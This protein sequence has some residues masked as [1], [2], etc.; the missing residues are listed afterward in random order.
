[1]TYVT[2]K[3]DY[4][5]IEETEFSDRRPLA[6]EMLRCKQE[7]IQNFAPPMPTGNSKLTVVV[8]QGES[9]EWIN[10]LARW[11]EKEEFSIGISLR[12]LEINEGC[13]LLSKNEYA[14]NNPLGY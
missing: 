10:I 13:C 4:V 9:G 6:V 3:I 12:E 2:Q 7:L 8:G 14:P 11:G 5:P 1:M